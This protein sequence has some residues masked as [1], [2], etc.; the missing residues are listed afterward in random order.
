LAGC[1]CA[2]RYPRSTSL[3]CSLALEISV[4]QPRRSSAKEMIGRFGQTMLPTVPSG[5]FFGWK[6]DSDELDAPDE[7]AHVLPGCPLMLM[8]KHLQKVNWSRQ[9]SVCTKLSVDDETEFQELD[10][11]E[12]SEPDIASR[13]SSTSTLGRQTS[14]DQ[15]GFRT[16]SMDALD[17]YA[18]FDAFKRSRRGSSHTIDPGGYEGSV[19]CSGLP[20]HCHNL[21]LSTQH[22]VS[23]LHSFSSDADSSWEEASMNAQ[24]DCSR[25]VRGTVS[26]S[27]SFEACT[28]LFCVALHA[29]LVSVI[30]SAVPCVGVS[31][32]AAE[33]LSNGDPSLKDQPCLMSCARFA[34]EV[35]VRNTQDEDAVLSFLNQE[36]VCA[37]AL[38]LLP[39]LIESLEEIMPCNMDLPNHLTCRLDILS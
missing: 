39:A 3:L 35:E 11:L 8:R 38:S 30:E 19:A 1:A 34:F 32:S 31:V 7:P 6:D 14:S 21:S 27:G 13:E 5:Y 33:E 23:Q 26:L 12:E 10:E 36:A 25:S 22:T 16:L 29:A 18:T 20:M 2:P 37:G 24:S 17:A 28:D 4:E 15:A 9:T